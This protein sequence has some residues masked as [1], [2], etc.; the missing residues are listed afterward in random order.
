MNTVEFV[1]AS[2]FFQLFKSCVV[3]IVFSGFLFF[4]CDYRLVALLMKMMLLMIVQ[5]VC[6][7]AV[8]SLNVGYG[9]GDGDGGGNSALSLFTHVCIH[10]CMH[11]HTIL[12]AYETCC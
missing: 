1:L 7:M 11:V 2:F 12:F 10:A 4:C 3:I 9:D 8:A 5:L 6:I